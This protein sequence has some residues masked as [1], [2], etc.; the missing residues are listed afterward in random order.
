MSLIHHSSSAPS[1]DI[2]S[3]L[4]QMVVDYLTDISSL[5][6]T[7]SNPL[8]QLYQYGVGYEVHQY[9][10]AMSGGREVRPELVLAL[11]E[12]Q[13]ETLDGFALFLRAEHDPS[14]CTVAYM[15]VRAS[16]RRRGVARALLDVIEQR[17][18]H[19]EL[20]C[21]VSKVSWFENMGFQVIG[22]QGP[23][24]KLSSDGETTDQP[25]AVLD[26][27]P[28]YASL[29]VRQIHA[30]LLNQHGRRAM[31]DAEKKRDRQ[32]DHMTR[33]AATFARDSQI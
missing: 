23:Q 2:K 13:P 33:Q 16:K 15:A 5:G 7:P 21:V 32:L 17:H 12:A 29:E 18:A 8:Y 28:I 27:A 1:E 24:V 20:A 10:E 25:I 30:Y 4:L 3:Q 9:L 26:V 31:L 19:V 6:I 11:D 14:V 22:A